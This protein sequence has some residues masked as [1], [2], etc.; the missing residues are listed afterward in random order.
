MEPKKYTIITVADMFE[1][2][3]D[4]F[5]D[6]LEEFTVMVKVMRQQEELLRLVASN[7]AGQ[8]V[9]KFSE[10]KQMVWI[11]DGKRSIRANLSSPD[12]QP[13]LTTEITRNERGKKRSKTNE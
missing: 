9:P 6:F 2:P 12:G 10:P 11:D 13:L 1:I 7:L 8:D 4:R 3:A 5:D